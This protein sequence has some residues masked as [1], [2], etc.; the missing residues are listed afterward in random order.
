MICCAAQVAALRSALKCLVSRWCE[1]LH[2]LRTA[3]NACMA[4]RTTLLRVAPRSVTAGLREIEDVTR[5]VR[6]EHPHDAR[7]QSARAAQRPTP[8]HVA[9]GGERTTLGAKVSTQIRGDR[10]EIYR[11][12]TQR[13]YQL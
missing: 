7:V 2:A 4:T 11:S 8:E 9:V 1:A 12:F 10:R 6:A 13:E 3:E 5:V